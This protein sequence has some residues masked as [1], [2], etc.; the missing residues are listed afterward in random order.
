MAQALDMELQDLVF[1]LTGF[2]PALVASFLSLPH[3][4]ILKWDCFFCIVYWK[5]VTGCS[6]FTAAHS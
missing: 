1:S 3:S 4:S 5:W 2:S 6:N